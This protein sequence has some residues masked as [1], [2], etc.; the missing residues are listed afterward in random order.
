V[1][2][3]EKKILET[4][5]TRGLAPRPY[6][7]FL[8]KR[9][10]F[11]TLAAV[12]ILL[13]AI[14]VAVLI[15]AAQ[16]YLTTGGRGFDEMPLDDVFEYLPYVWLATLAAFLAS[17]YYAVRHT[18]GGFRYKTWQLLSA[19]LAVCSVLGIAL[20]AAGAGRR[21]HSFLVQ[22]LPIYD[23]LTREREKSAPE[24]DKGVLTG[25]VLSFD[26]KA[27]M[28]LKDFTGKT[29]TVDVTGAKIT[30]DDPLAPDEDVEI[31]GTKTGANAFVAR[32][33]G[34]WE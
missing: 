12:S 6:A 4:I 2:D 31:H 18:S 33:I 9:S 34:D 21:V 26:G 20:H 16:D 29:W 32:S 30:L 14:S 24:P 27:T 23:S 25:T 19:T 10:V 28:V 15:F 3:F 13:G 17:A 8:A 1:T 22:S 11:W 7:Y 5:E